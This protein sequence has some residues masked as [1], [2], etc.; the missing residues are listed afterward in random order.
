MHISIHIG[1]IMYLNK[2][3]GD[4]SKI[5]SSEKYGIKISISIYRQ[6]TF[7]GEGTYTR[8]NMKYE[9]RVYLLMSR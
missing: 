3:L 5:S 1:L 4:F 2:Q 8:K 6:I 7:F 9:A